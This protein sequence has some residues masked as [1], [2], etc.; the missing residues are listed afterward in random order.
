MNYQIPTISMSLVA[1]SCILHMHTTV[2]IF[3]LHRQLVY[4]RGLFFVSCENLL[5]FIGVHS[6]HSLPKSL[7]IGEK[8]VS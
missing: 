6:F 3:K 1:R 4:L 2:Q 7:F 5:S 8:S